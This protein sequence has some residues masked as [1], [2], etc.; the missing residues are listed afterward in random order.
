MKN[1]LNIGF[2][3][4]IDVVY[5]AGDVVFTR[6]GGMGLTEQINKQIPFVLREKLIIN[7]RINKKLFSD[8]GLG[9]AMKKVSDAPKILIELYNN[10][11]KLEDMSKRATDLCKPNSTEDFVDFLLKNDKKTS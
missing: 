5:S 9:L 6:G 8:M 7:E 11:D 1:I 3:T 10:K 4:N 2:C